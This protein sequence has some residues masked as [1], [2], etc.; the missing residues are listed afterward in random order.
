MYG[1]LAGT[2]IVLGAILLF[3]VQPMV[4]KAILPWFG[5][6]AAV[7]TTCMLFF[8]TVLFLGYA[9][10]HWM[11]RRVGARAQALVHLALLGVSLWFLP[12]LPAAYWR[13]TGGE[14]PVGR[15]LALLAVAVGIPFFLLSSTSPLV[16]SWCARNGVLLPYRFF[17]LS[18]LASLAGLLGYPLWIEPAMKLEAQGRLW[19]GGFAA[20]GVC[21][22]VLAFLSR[23]G[24]RA[25][26]AEAVQ[27]PGWQQQAVWL[28]LAACGSTL[29]LAVTNHLCQN[30]APIPF[31]WVL[32]LA[33]YLL[34][35]IVCFERD[36]WYQ[37]PVVLPL[38]LASLAGAGYLLAS[39]GQEFRLRLMV[40]ALTAG[41]FLWCVYC[42]GELAKRKPAREHLTYFYLMV[43]LGGAAGAALVSLGAPFLLPAYFD[44]AVA[45]AACGLITLMM[46]YRKS[47]VT[48]I[49]WTALAIWLA[50]VVGAYVQSS[51]ANARLLTR[52]FYGSLR[53][54]ESGSGNMARRSLV[55]GVVT[56]GAQFQSPEKRQIATAYYGKGSGAQL[57][58]ENFRH[59]PQKVGV[60][61]LGVGTVAGYGRPGDTYRFYELNP[62]VVEA[63]ERE[64][65]FLADTP[66]N[67]ETVVGD[68]RLS[69][70]RE[71][72]QE[73][74]VLIVDAFSGDSIPSHL[75]TL[76]CFAIYL[77]H[78][79][80]D[81]VLALHVSNSA[82][83]VVQV[84]R[85]AA[86][87]LGLPW[88]EFHTDAEAETDRAES[89]WVLI[90]RSR[91]LLEK[92][93][94]AAAR[95]GGAGTNRAQ[96]WTDTYS[97]LISILK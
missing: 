17:A 35:F 58:I 31:L 25:A 96:P 90:A 97:S 74:D 4:A 19:S 56:H 3:L 28:V 47:V 95:R 5:G 9:Y 7:W 45:L 40:P 41:L 24:E 22:G 32:P 54:V 1:L 37:R 33:A 72:P 20:Y 26:G 50:V 51:R 84:V 62:A 10:A 15:I 64:F 29:S 44:L 23:R 73:F 83:D 27:K 52:N 70:E 46:E 93:S 43:A 8:Q 91:E 60:I 14:E 75:L 34:S 76:E 30:V 69:L 65:S 78:I 55:H 38:H 42:H 12:P 94:L 79:R 87:R 6:S 2:T 48:D 63:A 88:L 89:D 61:G 39:D 82:L 81:G 85:A 77:R 53:V 71:A 68:G 16:Q 18:N 11:N 59:S 86:L 80:Q 92:P 36:G 66:A 67:V 13:P 57:A 21:G 49:A